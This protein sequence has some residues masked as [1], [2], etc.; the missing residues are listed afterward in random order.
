MTRATI[1]FAVLIAA[2]G[3]KAAPPS[4]P[5]N[6]AP[7]STQ[8]A[9]TVEPVSSSSV[10]G[11]MARMES[12]VTRMCGCPDRACAELVQKDMTDWSVA[13]A[14]SSKPMAKPTDAMMTQMTE[15]GTRYAECMTT[16]YSAA[17]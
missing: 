16:I 14:K 3:G 8:P 4:P 7:E 9:A 5:Q 1:A 17:P 11:V 6:K 12:F 10:E 15:L 2:C 13:I